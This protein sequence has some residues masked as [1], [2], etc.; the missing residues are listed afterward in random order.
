M[1]RWIIGK[2]ITALISSFA[3]FIALFYL[4][5]DRPLPEDIFPANFQCLQQDQG[6][7]IQENIL[8]NNIYGI[9]LAYAKHINET[10][11]D[12]NSSM[13]PPI[14]RKSNVSLIIDNSN[15]PIPTENEMLSAIKKVE[16]SID[17]T[18]SNKG[19]S[20]S[21]LL[22]HEAELAFV[23]LEDISDKE[24]MHPDYIA[25]IGFLVANDLSARSIAILGD[26][27]INRYDYWGASKS[28]KGF[29]PVSN[30]I[31]VPK[32]QLSNSIPCVVLQTHIDGEL[33][34]NEN[35][36]NLIYTPLEMLK[37]IK[38]RYPAESFKKGDLILTGTPGGVILSVPR[39]KVRLAN[40]IGMDR[41]K[42]LSINQSK[43]NADKYLKAGNVVSVS[44]EWLGSVKITVTK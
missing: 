7:F 13:S 37:Y 22:D 9:G 31:W 6:D 23:L 4:Y 27:Q 40:I 41:F 38:D 26:G 39:W 44:A 18:L 28:F 16:P 42:K 21:S 29:T 30:R 34:Q 19:I 25:N 8:F 35:T 14:F 15:V 1:K 32:T 33:R 3:L 36:N 24:L 20:L 2:T 17:M 5:L 43:D 11:S 12:F 10:A